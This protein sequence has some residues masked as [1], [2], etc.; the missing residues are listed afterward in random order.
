[1]KIEKTRINGLYIVE[2]DRFT[3]NRGYFNRIY[4]DNTFKSLNLDLNL[5]QTNLSFN[6]KPGTVRG[7]HY[8]LPPY[9]ESKLVCC[10]NG[11][12]FDVIVDL[13]KGSSTYHEVFTVNLYSTESKCILIPK[14]CAHG[15]QTLEENT[16]I[17]YHHDNY[18]NSN[19]ERGIH[20]KDPRLSIDWPIPQIIISERDSKHLPLNELII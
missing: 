11:S 4:C 18:H 15:F 17:I 13:R 7:L 5:V 10:V 14:G 3:D 1:M 2:F 9:D 6:T 16:I 19:S 12:I 20:Y 8:Q